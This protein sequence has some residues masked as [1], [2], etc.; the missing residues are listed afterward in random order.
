M[1]ARGTEVIITGNPRGVF[2]EGT[3]VGTPLPGTIMEMAV[4][5]A[6]NGQHSYQQYQPGTDG[7]RRKIIILLTDSM[8]GKGLSD[9]YVSGSFGFMYVPVAGEEFNMLLQDVAGTGDVHP[10][11]ETL[12]VKN[13]T[14]KLIATT[15]TP[16]S[17][18]FR[19]LQAQAALTADTLAPVTYTGY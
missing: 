9:A 17:E 12:I 5:F 19:L 18:P 4:P 10:A 2:L 3:I 15:G 6:N 11:L 16:Q 13:G 14:G 8:Q 7:Q 1:A